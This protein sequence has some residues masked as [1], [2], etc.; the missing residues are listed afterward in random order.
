VTSHL[1]SQRLGEQLVRDGLLD[2]QGLFRALEHVRSSGTR[3]EDALLELGL[4]EER[5]LLKHLSLAQRTQFVSTERLSRA[6]IDRDALRAVP[7]R[8]AV[9]HAV[10]PLVL[11]RRADKLIVATADPE[12]ALALAEV[13]LVAGVATVVP[14]VARPA[15]V[16]AAILRGYEGDRSGFVRLLGDHAA[17]DHA[18]LTPIPPDTGFPLATPPPP[19]AAEVRSLDGAPLGGATPPPPATAPPPKTVPAGSP[20]ALDVPFAGDPLRE[21]P[22]PRPSPVKRRRLTPPW[23]P[24]D[25]SA[26]DPPMMPSDPTPV[27]FASLPP[28]EAAQI[29]LELGRSLVPPLRR[30]SH[31]ALSFGPLSARQEPA[32]HPPPPGAVFASP[33]YLETI[34]V[35]VG[36]LENDRPGLRGHSA[37]VARL[38]LDVCERIA[39]PK[40]HKEAVTLAAYLHDVGKMGRRHL[41]A[42][43]V[44]VRADHRAAAQRLWPIARD[45]LESVGLAEETKGALDSM[46]ECMAGGGL[47]AGLSGKDIPV[48]ARILA[49]VDSYAD[50]TL[51]A[52][53]THGKPLAPDAALEVL[54][55]Y[56]GTVFDPAVLDVL[57]RSTSGE[58][59]LT[60]LLADRHRVL[61]ADP[62]PEETMVLQL[63]LAE[64]GFDVH[65]ARSKAEATAL[66]A[67]HAFAL[68][69][70]AV[71]LDGSE[72]GFA[73]CTEMKSESPNT[74]WVFMVAADSRREAK[75]AFE[76][77]AEDV[78][79]RPVA[80]EIV[81]AKL[82]QILDRQ[83][84]RM[85][86]RGVAG[87][88]G[89]IGLT[90][91]V[92]MLWHGR[93][94]C[95]LYVTEGAH[96][97]RICFVEGRIVHAE[98][99]ELSGDIAVYR[100][101]ALGNHGD[102]VVD[103][104]D[105][106]R[107]AA[108]I[109]VSPEALLLEGTRL[110]DEAA[111]K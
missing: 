33:A 43:N 79:T 106:H 53:N 45:L 20:L 29:D 21:T 59:I 18:D 87:S 101:M 35:F 25:L 110:L 41:T 28:A 15:A 88:L 67:A 61:L 109:H 83:S 24:R 52:Q 111:L 47:P 75:R 69:L 37:A 17:T 91:L 95:S 68:V 85:G 93:K 102:F 51:N 39:L 46:Y 49:A 9:E 26:E 107:D 78:F 73:L 48:G 74:S 13:Q 72:G 31:A 84:R 16:G 22:K 8:L 92:Q 94:S 63:R 3:L 50:L 38:T 4:L 32:T 55:G 62:H 98:W 108:T 76:L 104:S 54:R 82:S 1:V 11:D 40:H 6:R 80:T 58:K 60:E 30:V 97:G 96:R 89:D 27:G 14:L 105:I 71:D 10:F 81:V 23:S 42:L 19:R 56:A 44:A 34:R 12:R 99:R 2:R 90:D 7:F 64:H 86:P 103:P 65:V 77:G 70:A 66:M 100:L 5:R 36:L 57:E